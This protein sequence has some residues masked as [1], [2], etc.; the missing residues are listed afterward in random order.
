MAVELAATAVVAA[1]AAASGAVLFAVAENGDSTF[2]QLIEHVAYPA[3]AVIAV[4][5][6]VTVVA[7]A[8]RWRRLWVGVLLGVRTG[9]AG[10]IVLEAVR[11]IGF[12]EFHSM[13]GDLPQLMGCC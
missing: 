11:E 6:V 8:A 5:A 3:A 7:A 4:I 12:R 13:P 2:P 9:I 1:A 10:T